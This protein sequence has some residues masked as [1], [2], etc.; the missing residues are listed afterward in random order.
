MEQPGHL[1]SSEEWNT[2]VSRRLGKEID[3]E[4]LSVNYGVKSEELDGFLG[5][6]DLV[7]VTVFVCGQEKAQELKFF[8]KTLPRCDEYYT[9]F[10]L[11]TDAFV[12]EIIVYCN[13][14]ELFKKHSLLLCD[15]EV[16]P[17]APR[18]YFTRTDLLVLEDLAAE[19]F[20]LFNKREYMSYQFCELV[21]K[22]LADFHAAS[23][24]CEER[25]SEASGKVFKLN[26]EYPSINIEGEFVETDG[27]SQLK[28]WFQAG[29][30]AMFTLVSKLNM[31][32]NNSE[33]FNKI[34]GTFKNK[35]E[36]MFEFVKPSNVYKNVICHGDLWPNNLMFRFEADGETPNEVRLLD[37]QLVRYAPPALDVMMF[38]HM[39][40]SR[41]FRRAHLEALLSL[42][43]ERFNGALQSHSVTT[44]PWE[45]FRESCTYYAQA[46]R[47]MAPYFHHVYL[48]PAHLLVP[49]LGSKDSF[50]MFN[51]DRDELVLQC[52]E[53]DLSY[54]ARL[55]EGLEELI[56][57][58]VLD[59]STD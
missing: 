31:Y 54:R 15:P 46:G 51:K 26:E 27:K 20:K 41:E 3:F 43:Y 13:V 28:H 17:W 4:L 1:L 29:I 25:E 56:E 40:S 18:C 16:T 59:L 22:L 49:V 10:I 32:G 34:S 19:G 50:E 35:C 6:H 7:Q 45:E 55:I 58:F 21:I 23:V 14:F 47:I 42:Y 5:D 36:L 39:V 8:L 11:S 24:I 12:K 30:K 37:F 33:H 48:M 2:V 9:K 44:I 52:F 38:L 53:E 57:C